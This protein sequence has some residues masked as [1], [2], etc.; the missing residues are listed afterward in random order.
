M[1]FVGFMGT[2]FMGGMEAGSAL[3]LMYVCYG[4]V[5]GLGT[6]SATTAASPAWPPGIRSAWA[7][8]PHSAH[9][10]RFGSLILGLLAGVLCGRVGGIF[11]VFR[12]YAVAIAVVLLLGSF[13]IK[14]PPAPQKKAEAAAGRISYT[15]GEMLAHA[16]FWIYFVWNILM[17]S[18]GMLVIN[19]S[20]NIAVYSAPRRASGW[21]CRSS[22]ASDARLRGCSW[23]SWE[24][25][26][27]VS[28]NVVLI[29]SGVLLL[30]AAQSGGGVALICLGM[31]LVGDLL[32]RRHRRAD[33]ADRRALRA[34][35]FAV[36]VSLT[37]F[38]M[39]PASF[40]DPYL[41]VLQ[42]RSGGDYRSNFVMLIAMAIIALAVTFLL[43]W[44]LKAEAKRAGRA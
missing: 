1:L 12:V 24:P 35:H 43:D 41:G 9:G 38:C 2:S 17:N 42:D 27:H 31:F 33:E 21:P 7:W 29:L 6:G 16:S 19:S 26:L 37:N 28:I 25:A 23:I 30:T 10:V 39:I 22:T 32:R 11:G 5:S 36:N 20:A 15:P 8:S 3:V 44:R 14:K 34:K 4:A 18:A 40:S 13:F